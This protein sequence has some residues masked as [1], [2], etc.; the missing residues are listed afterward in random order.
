M[1]GFEGK[2][3]CSPARKISKT[4]ETSHT[5]SSDARI[6][7][8]LNEEEAEEDEL[9]FAGETTRRKEKVSSS[10]RTKLQKK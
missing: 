10:S 6:N 4:S 7:I 8:D 9:E 3:H 1:E 5:T 2:R